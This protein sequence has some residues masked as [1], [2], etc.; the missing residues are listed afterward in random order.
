MTGL[1]L[2]LLF[3]LVVERGVLG[4][5]ATVLCALRPGRRP[6]C[7][8]MEHTGPNL[9]AGAGLWIAVAVAVRAVA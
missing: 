5:G 1:A 2:D 6:L 4:L 8:Q 9:A 3:N 7:E